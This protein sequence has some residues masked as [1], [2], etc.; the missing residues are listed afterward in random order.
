MKV[1]H[2]PFGYPPDPPGGTEVY[3]RGLCRALAERGVASAVAA[4]TTGVAEEYEVD[5]VSVHRF[6]FDPPADLRDHHGPGCP[7]AVRE[8]MRIV[9]EERADV[10]HLHASTRAVSPAIAHAARDAGVRVVFTYHTPS[11]TCARGSLLEWGRTPCDGVMIP[12]RCAACSL[13]GRGLPAAA[14]RLAALTPIA[15]GAAL[16]GREG[17][18]RTVLRARE[19]I[20]HR[21]AMFRSLVDA[22][23]AVVALAAWSEELLRRNG[24]PSG[25]LVV[26]RPALPHALAASLPPLRRAGEPLRVAF[27]G[28]ADPVKGLATLV[29]AV[30]ASDAPLSLDVFAVGGDARELG[31][32]ADPRIRFMDPVAPD[33]VVS[34]IAHYDV[35]AVPSEVKETGPLVVLEAFAAGVPVVGS[36]LGGIGELVV[37]K[38]DGILVPAGSVPGW[39]DALGALA[40]DPAAVER[41]RAGVRPPRTMDAV[42]GEMA[43][44]YARIAGAP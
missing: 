42:A 2:L 43:A 39:R 4:P 14:A 1:L 40:R 37:D 8:V 29:A 33:Q 16:A 25:K 7:R 32:A 9:R 27:F 28:R 18:V 13:H 17:R 21:A 35:L 23:D 12:G 41:L 15:V 19:L 34:T 36:A 20:A 31:A 3:V 26:S 24:V 44:L 38:V 6:G 30:R 22:A 5:G 10:V 11:L